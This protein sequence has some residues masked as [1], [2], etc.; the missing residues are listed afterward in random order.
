MDTIFHN[1]LSEIRPTHALINLSAIDYNIAQIRNR[2][3]KRKIMAIVKANGYGHGIV[4]VSKQA[5]ESG[6]E[7]LG[8]GFLEEGIFLRQ[9]DI[10]SPIL[11]MGGILGYQLK[12]FLQNDLEIT[13]SSLELAKHINESAGRQKVRVHLKIDTGMER[14]G[15]SHTYAVEFVRRVANMKNIEI[16]GIYSHFATA[17][18]ADKAFSATQHERFANVMDEIT[19]LGIEIEHRHIA[20]SGAILD[21][22]ETLYNMVRPGITLYG[23]YPSEHVMRSIL[24]RPAMSL[25][26]KVVFLKSVPAGTGISYG[27]QYKTD[28]GTRIATVPI[29]YGD[30]YSR[31]LTN[32]GEVLIRGRRHPVVGAVCMDQLMVDVGDAPVDIGDAVVLIGRQEDEEISAGDLAS[33]IGTIPYE[34][35]CMINARVPR[36]FVHRKDS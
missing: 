2:V 14:I 1:I 12:K 22:P 10:D 30:G 9:N 23:M 13:V 36:I 33:K 4:E 11:V 28:R 3:G 15:V 24:L 34:I 29:G 20:N 31:L 7:Y 21:L 25:R 18:D 32:K 17:D 6:V 27:L 5:I 26:S 35:T 8:V 19:K 16:V